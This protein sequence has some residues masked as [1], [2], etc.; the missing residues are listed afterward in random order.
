MVR[1]AGL[2]AVIMLLGACADESTP[3]ES[4]PLS[5]V[6]GAAGPFQLLSLGADERVGTQNSDFAAIGERL[7]FVAGKG[8]RFLS[9]LFGP[10]PETS[11]VYAVGPCG[12][13]PVVVAHDI[14]SVHEEP[15]WPGVAL[16]CTMDGYDLV[17]LDPSGVAGPVLLAA[18]ACGA[19]VTEHG[20]LQYVLTDDNLVSA[21]F[22]PLI[23][24]DGP[25]LGEPILV[26]DPVPVI[27]ALTG[28][29]TLRPDEILLLE[30]D[31]DLVRFALPDLTKTLLQP[32]VVT[33]ASSDDGRYLLFQLRPSSGDDPHNPIGMI[34]I[35]ERSSGVSILIGSGSLGGSSYPYFPVPDV[36]KVELSGATDHEILISLPDFAF[37]DVPAGHQI[38]SRLADGRWLSNSGHSNGWSVLDLEAG[39]T[40]LV[41]DDFALLRTY[42]DD[43]LDL[44]IGSYSDPRHTLPLV[45]FF[46][47]D[48]APQTLASRA[49]RNAVVREDGRILTM[50][51]VDDDW[52]GEL[53]LVDPSTREATRI[54]DRVVAATSLAW[55][56]HPSE[57]D[58]IVYGVVDGDRSGVWLARPAPLD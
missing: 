2:A 55:W 58:T 13:D 16:G 38:H 28:A 36:A 7:L 43:H 20:L 4:A 19:T 53:T 26:A 24:P 42:S 18:N 46:F 41:S 51:D 1:S 5:E 48:R 25:V 34:H 32:S 12:E 15:L 23:D 31:G 6:C 45:R 29:V 49:N 3:L 52:L 40:T 47:D 54:D 22:F 57:P 35:R 11:T 33:F 56:R 44:L 30:A 27:N 17:R 9:P 39:Q 21:N 37:L 8:Q 14:D 50:V 10:L